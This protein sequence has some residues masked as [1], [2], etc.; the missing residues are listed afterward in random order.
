MKHI[1]YLTCMIIF[2]FNSFAITAWAETCVM[3]QNHTIMAEINCHDMDEETQKDTHCNGICLCE[4]IELSATPIIPEINLLQE[5]L[6]HENTV[7]SELETFISKTHAPR[8]RPP[9]THA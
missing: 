9:I 3:H 8:L 1:I 5:P 6:A 7:I 2:L 4:H